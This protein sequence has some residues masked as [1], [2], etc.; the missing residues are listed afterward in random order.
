MNKDVEYKKIYYS[1]NIK[2]LEEILHGNGEKF[3]T[4]EFDK[5][6]EMKYFELLKNGKIILTQNFKDGKLDGK[7][8]CYDKKRNYHENNFKDGKL[9]KWPQK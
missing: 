3:S 9:V 1:K 6:G 2:V 5:N 7:A 4:T 8:T